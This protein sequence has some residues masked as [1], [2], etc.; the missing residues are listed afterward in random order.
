M[1]G[2][3]NNRKCYTILILEIILLDQWITNNNAKRKE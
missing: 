3:N 1:R 2:K